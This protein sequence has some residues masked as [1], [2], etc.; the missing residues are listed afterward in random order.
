[1]AKRKR[2]RGIKG[3]TKTE[4]KKVPSSRYSF[5]LFL[6]RIDALSRWANVSEEEESATDSD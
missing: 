5:S 3:S 6:R 4:A 1:L 2:M